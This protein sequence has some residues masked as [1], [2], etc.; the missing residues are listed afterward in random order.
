MFNL[1]IR[2]SKI[3][4]W[5]EP[6]DNL[7]RKLIVKRAYLGWVKQMKIH[8]ELDKNKITPEPIYKLFEDFKNN[9]TTD[10]AILSISFFHYLMLYR[11]TKPEKLYKRSHNKS[12]LFSRFGWWNI[13]FGF[14]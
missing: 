14:K 4:F 10:D 6:F 3:F 11:V 5:R 7:T 8:R 1:A 2:I 13:L 12:F 9:Y